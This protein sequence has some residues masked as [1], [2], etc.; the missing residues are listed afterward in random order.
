MRFPL[1]FLFERRRVGRDACRRREKNERD[2]DAEIDRCASILHR[3]PHRRVAILSRRAKIGDEISIRTESVSQ[4]KR[5]VA[6][7]HEE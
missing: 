6:G 7:E 3:G 4:R 1:H 2:A 5:A